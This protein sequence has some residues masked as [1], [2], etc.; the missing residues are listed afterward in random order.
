MGVV[1]VGRPGATWSDL[2]PPPTGK[3]TWSPPLQ[4]LGLPCPPRWRGGGTQRDGGHRPS[5]CAQPPWKA[6]PPA[7]RPRT[8]RRRR[9]AA[10]R[11]R[12]CACSACDAARSPAGSHSGAG[13][14]ERALRAGCSRARAARARCS[15]RSRETPSPPL[16]PPLL[17]SRE[18]RPGRPRT[19]RELSEVL[20]SQAP[21]D[22]GVS[23][24]PEGEGA[25]RARTGRERP[26]AGSLA[27]VARA[28]ASK[29]VKWGE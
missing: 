17:R 12:R 11:P 16:G 5:P 28:S 4:P 27:P 18:D 23:G 6:L 26:G 14:R 19:L 2:L 3:V 15:R 24:P 20:S 8:H 1:G 21:P 10:E 29:S 25:R 13:G 9:S 22:P 7:W